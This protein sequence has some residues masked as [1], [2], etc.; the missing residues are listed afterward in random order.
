MKRLLSASLLAACV[1]LAGCDSGPTGG[2][3]PTPGA[4][5]VVLASPNA[6]DAAILI[7]LDGLDMSN[8]VVSGTGRTAHVRNVSDTRMLV[9][10]FGPV[11][12]GEQLRFDV[13]DT[14][15]RAEYSAI[16]V[17]VSDATN[18]LRAT[19]SAYTLQVQR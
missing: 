8:V 12:S 6:S 19:P 18:A 10:I 15:K 16:V 1:L 11:S 14:K 5:K 13:P 4:L 2:G 3:A 17:D 9:A 7:R